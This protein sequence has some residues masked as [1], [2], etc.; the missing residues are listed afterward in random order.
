MKIILGF[1]FLYLFLPYVGLYTFS[2]NERNLFGEVDVY[3]KVSNFIHI[4]VVFTITLGF[5]FYRVS[6]GG[7]KS[8][9]FKT[10]SEI[11]SMYNKCILILLFCIL[12]MIYFGSLK[13]LLGTI[14]RGE[15]RTQLGFFGFFYNFVT[16]FLP[17]GIVALASSLYLVSSRNNRLR[18]HLLFIYLFAIIIGVSTG[19][20]YTALLI[21]SAGLM[22]LNDI[23]KYR[24]IFIVI[25]IFTSL[26][27]FSAVVFMQ[28][29]LE[30]AIS[31]LIA[32]ATSVA[33]QGTVA[34]WNIF[35]NGGNDASI[36]LLYGLGNNL[37]SLITG[38]DI[39]SVEFLKVNITRLIGYLTYPKPDEALSGAFNLTVSN[40]GEGV[41][42]FGKHFYFLFSIFTGGAIGFWIRKYRKSL[43]SQKILFN[44]LCL[45]YISNVL[46][47]WLMGG[48]VGNIYGIP[49]LVYMLLL[50]VFLKFVLSSVKVGSFKW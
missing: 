42:Y 25:I 32:R 38:Y 41:Y 44:T 29:D 11:T 5:C 30:V 24:T 20:K 49:T 26:M 40:F 6:Q 46:L 36:A 4:A 2:E 28:L 34:V 19:F 7:Y 47:P 22:Q 43:K 12:V 35:P 31:Y 45:I 3:L 16:L 39:Q 1:L 13:V 14:G 50:Y 21:A 18:Y 33:S 23:L 8:H 10:D 27:L 9:T 48:T 17:S 15:L 37:S